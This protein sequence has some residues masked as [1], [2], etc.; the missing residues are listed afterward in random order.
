MGL[1]FN[2]KPK[3]NTK[4]PIKTNNPA[5]T[6]EPLA[7]QYDA[8][9]VLDEVAD[10]Q[11]AEIAAAID[12]LVEAYAG[13]TPENYAANSYE[14]A[15]AYLDELYQAADYIKEFCEAK[16]AELGYEPASVTPDDNMGLNIDTDE[17]VPEDVE[18]DID[19]VA[20]K[21]NRRKPR[22][23]NRRRN[24][25]QP[26]INKTIADFQKAMKEMGENENDIVA[27]MKNF[28][29]TNKK[30][31]AETI[32]KL[33]AANPLLKKNKLEAQDN[34]MLMDIASGLKLNVETPVSYVLNGFQKQAQAE[35]FVKQKITLAEAMKANR[36]GGK[37]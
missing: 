5:V 3:A 11:P 34:E 13:N 26:V 17:F 32:E 18:E 33:Q 4:P 28:S 30:W 21:L 10:L 1:F 19:E 7:E 35:P 23:N 12:E 6:N 29:E 2:R 27:N 16:M 25:P 15:A 20:Q 22:T 14:E 31:R 24:K 9:E 37:K 8:K 36:A